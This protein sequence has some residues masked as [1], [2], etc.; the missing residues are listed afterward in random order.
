[1]SK[2]YIAKFRQGHGA[3]AV[4]AIDYYKE[5][6]K[7]MRHRWAMVGEDIEEVDSVPDIIEGYD[8]VGEKGDGTDI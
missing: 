7:I 1:M 8:K 2:E 6:G 5:Y 3:M 4:N